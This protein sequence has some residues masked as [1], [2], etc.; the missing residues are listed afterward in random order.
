[1]FRLQA[2]LVAVVRFECAEV[3]DLVTESF[4]FHK[5]SGGM[6]VAAAASPPQREVDHRPEQQRGREWMPVS[7]GRRC[8]TQD[9]VQ[10]A[11]EFR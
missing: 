9:F 10:I 6:A 7:Q 1:M 8:G 4:T 2:C 3:P 11:V 5:V